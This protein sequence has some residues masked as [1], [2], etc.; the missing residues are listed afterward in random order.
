[1]TGSLVLKSLVIS[2]SSCDSRET[3][4]DRTHGSGGGQ[5]D[6]DQS[7]TD[8]RWSRLESVLILPLSFPFPTNKNLWA[9]PTRG[10]SHET[11]NG[12]NVSCTGRL[13]ARNRDKV[14]SET[15]GLFNELN[16]VYP[17][18]YP[19]VLRTTRDNRL[20][21]LPKHGSGEVRVSGGER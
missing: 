19:F 12:V 10:R 14:W 1:M 4:R 9:D 13:L 11:D 20:P 5:E 16:R 21:T 3:P 15:P 17:H 7:D 8:T 2:L 6:R 18:H